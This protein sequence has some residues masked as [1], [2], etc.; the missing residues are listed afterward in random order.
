MLIRPD[1]AHLDGTADTWLRA[2]VEEKSFRGATQQVRVNIRG[3]KFRFEFPANTDLPKTGEDILLGFDR[4]D[5]FQ[6]F[7]KSP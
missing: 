4:Q 5:A 3:V 1:E 6:I 7:P 2:I